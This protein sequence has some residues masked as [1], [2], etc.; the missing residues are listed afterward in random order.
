MVVEVWDKESDINNVADVAQISP[1][2]AALLLRHMHWKTESTIE[3][4]LDNSSKLSTDAGLAPPSAPS[5][6]GPERTAKRSASSARTTRSSAKKA[7]PPPQSPE[8]ARLCSICFDD[9][10][11]DM[12]SLTCG[13]EFCSGCWSAFTSSKIRDEGE[14][15]IACMAEG[16][17]L[18]APDAFVLEVVR[19]DAKAGVRYKELLL[20]DFVE[21][22]RALKFCPYPEC[23][24]AVRCTAAAT[25]SS[26]NTIVPAVVCGAD[27]HHSFC[28]GCAIEAD[29]RPLLC[30]VSKLW[31][32]KCLDDSETANWIKSNTKE[33][34]KCQSTIE[35]N[36]GCKY[37]DAFAK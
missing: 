7:T 28:F 18:I 34:V 13:H 24:H 14:H 19:D 10:A 11:T 15:S 17:K 5:A 37:V 2:A 21:A 33:C 4:Y 20:R 8:E 23:T 27:E 26:L 3:A 25:K 16:C 29:H 31:L 1:D 6:L 30:A 12:R 22:Q 36:G 9:E 35:K 32:Q